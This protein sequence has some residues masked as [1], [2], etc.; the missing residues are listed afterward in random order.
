M[1][2]R[3]DEKTQNAKY[4]WQRHIALLDLVDLIESPNLRAKLKTKILDVANE[5][6]EE[7]KQKEE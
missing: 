7:L 3:K 5:I 1:V 6:N 4:Y 2:E